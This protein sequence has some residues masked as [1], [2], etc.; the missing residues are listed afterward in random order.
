MCQGCLNCLDC[1]SWRCPCSCLRYS[2]RTHLCFE[3]KIASILQTSEYDFLLPQRP[4]SL[5]GSI[6]RP[7]FGC[8]HRSSPSFR[9][10][11]HSSKSPFSQAAGA[12]WLRASILPRLWF[13]RVVLVLVLVS[14]FAV[15]SAVNSRLRVSAALLPVVTRESIPLDPEE[16]RKC[17]ECCESCAN[18]VMVDPRDRG[19]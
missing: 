17:C 1:A 19:W 8:E 15:A 12:K 18:G 7:T 6:H 3:P 11:P 13:V 10:H 14:V 2:V 4:P 16:E 5:V 9:S